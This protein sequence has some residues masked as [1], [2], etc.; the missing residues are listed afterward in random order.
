MNIQGID[1]VAPTAVTLRPS[2][3][4]I[5]LRPGLPGEV[6]SLQGQGNAYTSPSHCLVRVR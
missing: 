1:T 3:R 5:K 4:D 2:Q 6:P